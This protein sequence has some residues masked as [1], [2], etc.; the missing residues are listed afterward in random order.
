MRR[1]VLPFALVCALV[2]AALDAQVEV[3]RYQV[4]ALLGLQDFAASSALERAPVAGVEASYY[5][6]PNLSLGLY[7]Q[8]GRPRTDP[9]FFPLVRLNFGTVT[10]Y[11]APAQRVTAYALGVQARVSMPLDF[12]E[13]Y[14]VLGAGGYLFNLDPEQNRSDEFRSGPTVSIGAGINLPLAPSAGVRVELR[15]NVLLRFNRDWFDLSDP[16]FRE[17]RHPAPGDAWPEKQSTIHNLR[18]SLGFT[19]IPGATR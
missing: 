10:E 17:P 13:P 9:L 15:D 5:L 7:G 14:A 16:L 6:R 8:V 12:A 11:H 4:S 18:W 1:I 19:F 3:G 2:P